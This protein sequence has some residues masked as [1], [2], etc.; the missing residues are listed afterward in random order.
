MRRQLLATLRAQTMCR[1]A[2]SLFLTT[3]VLRQRV[4]M[5]TTVQT[6]SIDDMFGDDGDDD[7]VSTPQVPATSARLDELCE[8]MPEASVVQPYDEADEGMDC[9]SDEDMTLEG[10]DSEGEEI[11]DIAEPL[12]TEGVEGSPI[13][14]V[15]PEV[16]REAG[17]DDGT[18]GKVDDVELQM[19]GEVL[20]TRRR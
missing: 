19:M 11:E 10:G 9:G 6:A 13:K 12:P 8:E 1:H 4:S 14:F 7:E 2:S 18:D 3:M 20:E 16:P 17:S 5:N 15:E